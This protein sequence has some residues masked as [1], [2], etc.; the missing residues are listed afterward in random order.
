M[1]NNINISTIGNKVPNTHPVINIAKIYS[2]ISF[3]LHPP[4][5]YIPQIPF[6][7]QEQ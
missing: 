2:I 1:L 3:I 4:L 5:I 6:Y 7:H